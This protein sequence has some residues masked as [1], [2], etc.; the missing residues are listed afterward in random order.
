M[1]SEGRDMADW[2]CGK[3]VNLSLGKKD[4]AEEEEEEVVSEDDGK[5]WQ[6]GI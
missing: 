4:S 5:T 1:I 6:R 2:G 3:Q